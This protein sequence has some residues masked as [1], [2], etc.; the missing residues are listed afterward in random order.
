MN[1]KF[2]VLH[3]GI[4]FFSSLFYPFLF[5][6][7]PG[8]TCC[9]SFL[10]GPASHSMIISKSTKWIGGA[11]CSSKWHNFIP[12]FMVGNIPLY[13]C[14]T[15][16]C[17]HLLMDSLVASM[18]WPFKVVLQWHWGSCVF[19]L[20]EFIRYMPRSGITDHVV[21]LV[22]FLKEPPS[23]HLQWLLPGYIPT[24]SILEIF[25]T[26]PSPKSVPVGFFF[27]HT[28]THKTTTKH[29]GLLPFVL[30]TCRSSLYMLDINPF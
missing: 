12:F 4:C 21:A 13:T 30:L 27:F 15:S 9:L 16:S 1:R 11:K 22:S 17:T 2:T 19:H 24:Q 14:T 20:R 26:M 18:S 3:L 28:H 10:I 8:I 7:Q 5:P 29:T 6:P 25:F 23:C